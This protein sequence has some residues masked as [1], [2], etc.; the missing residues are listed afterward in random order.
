MR[1]NDVTS[2]DFYQGNQLETVYCYFVLVQL[3]SSPGSKLAYEAYAQEGP[4]PKRMKGKRTL[5]DSVLWS[6]NHYFQDLKKTW[7][8]A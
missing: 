5:V 1:Q 6:L 7:I 4:A 3:Q 2:F 8:R